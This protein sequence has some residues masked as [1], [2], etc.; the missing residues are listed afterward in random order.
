[1]AVSIRSALTS[2]V[3]ALCAST[4]VFT[5]STNPALVN[6]LSRAESAVASYEVELRAT[7][8]AIPP[9]LV[10]AV[11]SLTQSQVVNLANALNTVSVAPTIASTPGLTAI[12]DAIDLIYDT[13][14]PWVRYGFDVAAAIISWIPWVGIF[15]NQI[16]VFYNFFEGMI[17]S[18]VYNT[19]DWMRGQGSAVKNIADWFVDAGLALVWLGIDEVGAWVPLPPTG[20][21]PP[22]PPW[23]D[24]PEG[25]IGNA[26]V[27]GS[28][29]LAAGSNWIWDLWEPIK[30]GINTGVEWTSDLLDGLA[31]IPF[32]PLINFQ[33]TA[34]WELIADGVD[35]VAGFAHDMIN[36][37]DKFVEDAV[38]SGLVTAT[39][40]ATQTTWNSIVARLGEAAQAWVDW[41]RAQIDWFVDRFTPGTLSAGTQ[42][43]S[44]TTMSLSGVESSTDPDD[45]EQ[46]LDEATAATAG[47]PEESEDGDHY[48]GDRRGRWLDRH[49]G[50]AE[51]KG[52]TV[53]GSDGETPD[54]TVEDGGAGTA[55]ETPGTSTDP[56]KV[57]TDPDKVSTDPDKV[58]TDPDKVSTDPDKVSRNHVRGRH[59][60]K[61][62]E[63][64]QNDGGPSGSTNPDSN[65]NAQPGKPGKGGTQ[66]NRGHAAAPSGDADSKSDPSAGAKGS[67]G[68]ADSGEKKPG[69]DGKSDGGPRK[70]GKRNGHAA[71]GDG[72]SSAADRTDDSAA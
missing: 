58:S 29:A 45:P 13:V 17:H 50:F 39:V 65:A 10:E 28:H 66:R 67:S 41:G 51:L 8:L 25:F 47:G 61:P 35:A 37:G 70:H 16:H 54:G 23:A 69:S 63:G 26:L 32:V 3:G 6:P 40:N 30:S 38:N 24:L 48:R 15:A 62:D 21:Y 42:Q 64:T 22:R 60:S 36:A 31:W 34:G 4:I 49:W 57:S 18:G 2:G 27:A 5:A 59:F 71:T 53:D 56:D 1:V 68:G 7:Q 12:A 72:H 9:R 14:E 55:V 19:T 44:A 46:N 11:S 43:L 52:S 20:L 33:I